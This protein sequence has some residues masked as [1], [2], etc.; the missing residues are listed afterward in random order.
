MAKP[1]TKPV[2]FG[3]ATETSIEVSWEAIPEAT[4]YRLY[5]IDFG[6]EES[7]K[8]DKVMVHKFD[9]KA[10]KA[11]IEELYPTS[12]FC[13]K[14]V[15]FNDE[16]DFPASKVVDC[17][18]AVANCAPDNSTTITRCNNQGMDATEQ[19]LDD[20]F[21]P[22]YWRALVPW[23]H[24]CDELFCTASKRGIDRASLFAKSSSVDFDKCRHRMDRDG[25]FHLNSEQVPWKSN[26]ID[27]DGLARAVHVLMKH[28]WDPSF[29]IVY[30]EAWAI[31][32]YLA[33]LVSRSSGGNEFNMDMI[34][35]FVDPSLKTPRNSMESSDEDDGAA[36]EKAMGQKREV[37]ATNA[38]FAPH[39]DRMPS[40]PAE[41]FRDVSKG[42]GP[43]YS[44]IWMALTNATCDNSCLYVVPRSFDP[45]YLAGDPVRDVAT[46]GADGKKVVAKMMASPLDAVYASGGGGG[47]ALRSAIRAVPV[48]AGGIVSISHR[49]IHW[50]SEGR[51]DQTGPPRIALAF[52]CSDDEFEAPILDRATTMPFPPLALRVSLTAGQLLR[53]SR[54]HEYSRRHLGWLLRLFNAQAKRNLFS[55]SYTEKARSDYWNSL[56]R[57]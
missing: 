35:F 19:S 57:C 56:M 43:K 47:M 48:D 46:T 44:T 41:S 53:Y 27:V 25:Y 8:S 55:K 18:T 16:G 10:T 52:G 15:A 36:E 38:G 49:I 28:G 50:G 51:P 14:L 42:L 5:V 22:S 39:R 33:P 26:D 24:V 2:K 11:K 7:W 34:T 17:D 32:G 29:L 9:G 45:G 30:D 23:L 12:T 21:K 54:R 4:G 13:F 6:I 20:L 1:Q 37:G 3:E 31:A 40:R